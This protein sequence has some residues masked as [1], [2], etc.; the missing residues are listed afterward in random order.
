MEIKDLICSHLI[1]KSLV[2]A[3][4]KGRSE[5]GMTNSRLSFQ[6]WLLVLFGSID[7]NVS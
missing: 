3:V 4:E 2:C 5:R 6:K 7:F 1:S